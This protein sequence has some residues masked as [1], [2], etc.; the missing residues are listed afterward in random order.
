MVGMALDVHIFVISM[1]F[2]AR[3][4]PAGNK[5]SQKARAISMR[6]VQSLIE[7][8]EFLCDGRQP[9]HFPSKMTILEDIGIYSSCDNKGRILDMTPK[10]TN[11]ITP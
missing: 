1:Q 7:I 4:L 8:E 5:R 11:A 9:W 10:L 3:S 2:D 6:I